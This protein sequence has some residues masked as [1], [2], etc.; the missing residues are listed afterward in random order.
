MRANGTYTG[1]QKLSTKE[2]EVMVALSLSTRGGSLEGALVMGTAIRCTP[3]TILPDGEVLLKGCAF[4][5]YQEGLNPQDAFFNMGS[6]NGCTISE[7][8]RL[9]GRINLSNNEDSQFSQS[10]SKQGL[11]SSA[12]DVSSPSVFVRHYAYT[13]AQQSLIELEARKNGVTPSTPYLYS[14]KMKKLQ[15]NSLSIVV[16]TMWDS[17]IMMGYDPFLAAL[18][19]LVTANPVR[20]V[21]IVGIHAQ[22][23]ALKIA[24][25]GMSQVTV[26]YLEEDADYLAQAQHPNVQSFHHQAIDDFNGVGYD[27]VLIDNFEIEPT[28]TVLDS[29]KSQAATWTNSGNTSDVFTFNFSSL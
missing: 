15:G 8:V 23:V 7:E 6:G 11:L 10:F 4:D 28:T 3:A 25:L 22:Q 12:E 5:S 2:I 19:G 20:R 14:G 17:Y 26:E 13:E 16:G 21:L 9:N 18:Q 27:L 1:L 24:E 29:A